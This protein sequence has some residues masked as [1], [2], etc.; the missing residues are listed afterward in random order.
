[1]KRLTTLLALLFISS[2]AQAN[3]LEGI[4]AANHSTWVTS[5]SLGPAWTNPGQSQTFYL[6]P[7]AEKTFTANRKSETL[8]NSEL[9]LGI[10]KQLPHAFQNQLGLALAATSSANLSG[11]IWDDAE[12]LFNNYTY[13]YQVQHTHIAIKDKLLLS[14]A[15]SFLPWVSAS[16]GVGFNRASGFS[17]TPSIFEAIAMP[18]FSSNTETSFTYAFGV[19]VQK[20]INQHWQTGVGYEFANWGKSQLGSAP[21]QTLNS[22]LKLNHLYTQNLMF[23]L[24]YIG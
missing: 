7:E 18:N 20:A 22:G 19:G 17:N 21:G 3:T 23:N 15:Y 5:L 9:F 24:T 10:Q 12:P 16:L 11:N 8:L 1:M 6:A 13:S 4:L 14:S 2:I